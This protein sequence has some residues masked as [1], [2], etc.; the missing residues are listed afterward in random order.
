M[1]AEAARGGDAG[2]ALW[3]SEVLVD[4]GAAKVRFYVLDMLLKG[5]ASSS[6]R[7]SYVLVHSFSPFEPRQSPVPCPRP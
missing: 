3:V 5:R 4:E 2:E 1:S 7:V 6:P